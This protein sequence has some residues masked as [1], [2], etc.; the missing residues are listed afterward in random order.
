VITNWRSWVLLVLLVGPILAYM[1]FGAM[2]LGERGWLLAA[3]GL[4]IAAGIVFAILAERWTKARRPLLPPLD[5][6]APQTFSAFDREAWKLVEAEADRS[7]TIPMEALS[8]ADLYINT[9]RDLARRLAAHYHPLSHDPIEHVPIVDLLTALELA[10]EDLGNLCRQ[11]PG[12][13]L[14]TPAHWKHA[15]RAAGYIQKAN[16][17]YT[18][19]LPIFQPMTGLVRLGTQKLMVGPAWKN[20]QQNLMRWFFRAYVNRL[21][22]HLVELYSGRLVIGADHYRRLTRKARRQAEETAQAPVVAVA[23][24]RKSG[25]SRLIVALDRVRAGDLAP[26]R[27][28]LAASG[29]DEALAD[30]LKELQWLEVPGYKVKPGQD[31]ARERATRREAVEAAVEADLLVLVIDATR[32]DFFEDIQ[33]AQDWEAWFRAHPGRDVPPALAVVTGGDRL[34]PDGQASPSAA[35]RPEGPARPPCAPAWRS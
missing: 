35:G 29:L 21:G 9:G 24:A 2:W 7:E 13:D 28:R 22:T 3:A 34:D 11:M 19:L 5:W 4:W 15:V 31:T 14:V 32:D 8:G 6:E 10:A 16:D 33:F 17:I 26:V 18:Y 25:K 30:R 1:G 27:A 20:M 12:G 23:G